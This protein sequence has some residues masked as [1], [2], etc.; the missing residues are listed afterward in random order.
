MTN[1]KL[2]PEFLTAGGKKQF[3]VIPYEEFEALQA[4]IEDMFDLY[5]L[6]IAEDENEGKPTYTISEVR[7]ELGLG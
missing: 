6:R 4:W 1:L 5:E 2:H 3:A 7:K